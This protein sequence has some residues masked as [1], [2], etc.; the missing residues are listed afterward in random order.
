MSFEAFKDRLR[1]INR[2][3]INPITLSIAGRPYSPHAI[4]QHEGRKSGNIYTTPILVKEI[5]DG[6]VIPL[7]YG[8]DTDWCRNVIAANGAVIAVQGRAYR[9]G[10]PAVIPASEGVK[11]FPSWM[12]WFLNAAGTDQYL[13]VRRISES[14]EPQSIYRI[15]I[16]DYPITRAVAVLGGLFLFSVL[17]VLWVRGFVRQGS[18]SD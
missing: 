16:A 7:P 1:V 10:H 11:A 4:I 9:V 2:E 14:P 15:I 13:R 6:F 8:S 17:S 12:G 18:G 3:I 5:E